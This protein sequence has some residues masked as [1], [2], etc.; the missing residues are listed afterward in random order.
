MVRVKAKV[1]QGH[2]MTWQVYR[3]H[4]KGEG[5]GEARA[6]HDIAGHR[7]AREKNSRSNRRKEVDMH[8]REAHKIP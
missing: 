3:H 1:K 4:G 2:G 8:E 7:I 5:E 6:W